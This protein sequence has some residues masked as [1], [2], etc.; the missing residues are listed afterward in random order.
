MN[1]RQVEF[2]RG[3]FGNA[4]TNRNNLKP[5]LARARVAMW[6]SILRHTISKP[7]ASILEV[8]A[9]IG[10]NLRAMRTLTSARLLALE[11]NDKARTILVEDDV[12]AAAD[13]KAGIASAI[14]WPDGA[15]DLVFTSGV[16]IHIH[17]DQLHASMREIHR[18]AARWV[19]SVEY[20]ADRPTE[21]AYRGNDDVL[22]KRD[23]GAEWLQLFPTLRPVAYGFE[24]KQVTGLDNLTWWLFEKP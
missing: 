4:Y 16:L 1:D 12:V 3:D 22:F 20:F 2:W 13:V 18:C 14:D 17:P 8:G 15:A 5:D 19:L 23:F 9:N 7:P 11:P 24:W 10:I 21:V 6:A